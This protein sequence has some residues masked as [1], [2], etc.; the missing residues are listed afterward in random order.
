M[1]LKNLEKWKNSLNGC[2]RCGYCSTHCPVSKQT[3]WGSDSPRAK[4]TTVFG[5][6]SGEIEPS[7]KVTNKLS[8]CFY[9]RRCVNVCSS[10]VPLTDIF[11]DAKKDLVEAG[12]AIE[13]TTTK[14]TNLCAKCLL[15]LNECPHGART[16]SPEQ[17]QIITDLVKCQSCGRCVAVCPAQ[18]VTVTDGYGTDDDH[19]KKEITLFFDKEKKPESKAV[20]FLCNWSNYPG[21]Q[22]S[23]YGNITDSVQDYKVIVNMC[24][25]R[26]GPAQ[27]FETFLNG[28][29]G[30]MIS[31]CPDGECEHK[32]NVKARKNVD[33]VRRDLQSMGIDPARVHLIEISRGSPDLFQAEVDKFM[34]NLHDLGPITKSQLKN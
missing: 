23:E 4:L 14:T 1:E 16:F 22:G 15:C 20:I 12:F 11:I 32:G 9:C 27:I 10:G 19:I 24:G 13:G 7:Q 18:A 17:N 5:L 2:I 33:A 26:L 29:W 3:G 6:L 28:G 31:T 34:Q 30:V 25:G 21:L 8:T